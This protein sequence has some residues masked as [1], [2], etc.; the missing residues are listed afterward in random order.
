LKNLHDNQP[1][2]NHKI[3]QLQDELDLYKSELSKY[4][5]INDLYKKI[6]LTYQDNSETKE[7]EAI[8]LET[9]TNPNISA[10]VYFNYSVFLPDP[11][12]TINDLLVVGHFHIVNTSQVELNNPFIGLR[13]T[14]A[15]SANISGKIAVTEKTETILYTSDEEWQHMNQN[16]RVKI[17]E[18]GEYWL[19]PS[20]CDVIKPGESL[21][22]TN[23][24]LRMNKLESEGHIKVEGICFTSEFSEGIPAINQISFY[25]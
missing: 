14:P 2:E 24:D 21:S 3:S 4:K 15:N 13:V 22:F 11:K 10:K 12:E 17:R 19:K 1:N 8:N 20:H 16:W 23:F 25:H 9:E 18:Q 5:H 6:V 7:S